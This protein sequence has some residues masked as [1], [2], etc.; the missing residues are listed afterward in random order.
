MLWCRW[1]LFIFATKISALF[2]NASHA[3]GLFNTTPSRRTTAMQAS[4]LEPEGFGKRAKGESRK[5]L[6]AFQME[7]H[8]GLWGHDIIME[9]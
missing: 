6:M 3:M 1:K 5:I 7:S 8:K 4:L 2:S 9:F